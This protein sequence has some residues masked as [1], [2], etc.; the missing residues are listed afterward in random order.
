MSR[1][2][3]RTP[4]LG[5]PPSPAA[6]ALTGDE[7]VEEVAEG[8]EGEGASAGGEGG[9]TPLD[10]TLERIG[11]GR[12][13]KQL[14]VLCGLG[15]AADNMWLQAVAVVLPRV[16]RTF[17]VEDRWIG[18]LSTSIFAGMMVG[19]WGW[20]SY[21][22]ARGRLPAF[23]LTLLLASVFGLASAFAPS[24]GWLCFALFLLGTG[25]G[26]S[27]PT[28]GTL[29]LENIP[30]TSHFLLTGLSVFFSFGAIFTSVLGLLIL[31]R[32][33]CS[34]SDTTGC[35]ASQE[36]WRYM[37]GV[38]GLVSI[39]M[40]ISRV[41][42][43]RLQESAKF[44][45]AANQPTAA[46]FALRRISKM[47]GQDVRWALRDVVDDAPSSAA[48]S[49]AG[50]TRGYDATSPTTSPKRVPCSLPPID[51]SSPAPPDG[52]DLDLESSD[53]CPLSY[54]SSAPRFK[55]QDRPLWFD[56]LPAAWQDGVEEYVVRVA[57]LLKEG[58][59]R[60]TTALVWA[61]WG[62]ASAGY[63]IFNVFLPKFLETKLS[64]SPDASAEQTLRDY[65][66][67]TVAG[68]PGSLLGAWLV[69]T[70]W[71]RAKTLA[72]ST[73][74]TSAA[75]F[76]F[77]FV[78]SAA[79]V[80]LS[81]MAVSLA[82]TL[83]YAV[84]Y[85]FTPELFPTLTR[86]TAT[87]LSSAI[88]RLSGIVAPLLT[89]ILL[90]LSISLPLFVSG[91][92]NMT[93]YVLPPL[94]TFL[95]PPLSPLALAYLEDTFLLTTWLSLVLLLWDWAM[96]LS[97]ER[98][99][100]TLAQTVWFVAQLTVGR[101]FS[102][103]C[104]ATRALPFGFS[105]VGFATHL[106]LAHRMF[107]VF[108]GSLAVFYPLVAMAVIDL[109]LQLAADVLIQPVFLT[110]ALL[111]EDDEVT[112]H[113]CY[114]V[115]TTRAFSIAF[116]SPCVVGHA[117]LL[118]TLLASWRHWSTEKALAASGTKTPSLMKCLR[119]EHAGYVLAMCL[120]N[121]ANA[122]LV[123]QAGAGPY[124]L[125]WYLPALVITHLLLSRI[126]FS[127]ERRL[128]RRA[129]P[130]MATYTLPPVAVT[131]ASSPPPN[132][133]NRRLT[134]ADTTAGTLA[135]IGDG[136]SRPRSAP[137]QT[138]PPTKQ[139]PA[140]VRA[141]P[142]RKQGEPSSSSVTL[143][144]LSPPPPPTLSLSDPRS[145]GVRANAAF[146]PSS[147]AAAQQ[148]GDGVS[149]AVAVNTQPLFHLPTREIVRQASL[150]SSADPG[151]PASLAPSGGPSQLAFP[152]PPPRPAVSA[153]AAPIFSTAPVTS[154]QATGTLSTN[155]AN[156]LPFPLLPAP[157]SLLVPTS[158]PQ[159]SASPSH[160]RSNYAAGYAGDES[161][162][163]SPSPSPVPAP[164][165]PGDAPSPTPSLSTNSSSS[166]S[167]APGDH[168]AAPP[169]PSVPAF[170]HHAP[171]R[172]RLLSVISASQVDGYL[173]RSASTDQRRQNEG[174]ASI[175]Q[176][177]P[178][179]MAPLVEKEEKEKEDEAGAA[180]KR[181]ASSETAYESAVDPVMH[182]KQW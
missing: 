89:G 29:F 169:L 81:S 104:S 41:L 60:R 118:L 157:A 107:C 61:V 101:S 27:M 149:Q 11:I 40:F 139:P 1:Q 173:S 51:A 39:A 130:P 31:P 42:F 148:G 159:Q 47:N 18:L 23:N 6:Q 59:G 70:S 132:T 79:G 131:P 170:Y 158:P 87:G 9:L 80:V 174:R 66:L 78:E 137:V 92:L 175:Q 103:A 46:V 100:L 145:S 50:G 4:L 45:V 113:L 147:E 62:L 108:T 77:V 91:S 64:S 133:L 26:G 55:D 21:S 74:A 88:S 32:F 13:Q 163:P 33:S 30:K 181:C 56:R 168:Q 44:L 128:D 99:Y 82:G 115:P 5:S 12:Y 19:A 96:H 49:P 43:F 161:A 38:L 119:R 152:A 126:W 10:E 123:L 155:S 8:G 138:T 153:P 75:T 151:W 172:A 102:G 48:L 142:L 7:S 156:T 134:R 98:S 63:T 68:L 125:I 182:E 37:L 141:R 112:L 53:L 72:F 3:S 20:G 71:G 135:G 160:S 69:E 178:L 83:M 164:G 171:E 76:V 15:W 73:L 154:G 127:L 97:L 117:V 84:I 122:I 85:S 2:Q 36:G 120:V 35:D 140:E 34:P 105:V 52:S 165:N 14:L 93:A 162:S 86:G 28:D 176:T 95:S 129:A 111:A 65:V 180:L 67:Y 25:V 54:P 114:M 121:F 58:E 146:S 57:E 24:F 106:V 94:Q 143:E 124:Q 177:P 90:S 17:E 109:G 167:T 136:I 150:S 16:Q 166:F 110:Y 116:L 22:D 179:L 144:I